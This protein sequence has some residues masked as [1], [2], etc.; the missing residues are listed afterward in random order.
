[1]FASKYLRGLLL[2]ALLFG[3]WWWG[4][5]QEWWNSFI[6]P[7]PSR[8]GNVAVDLFRRGVLVVHVKTSLLRILSGC[9]VAFGTAFPLGVLCGRSPLLRSLM[10]PSLEAL[11]HIP[12]LA[13][14]PLLILWFGIGETSK[15]MVI[16]MASFFPIF[17]NTLSGIAQ[18][19]PQ[20]L[21]V[22]TSLE[23]SPWKTFRHI[24]LPGALPSV[25]VGLRLG[26]GYS[27][28]ALIGAELIAAASGI[29]Y[30]IHDAEQLSRTDVVIVG[31][32]LMGVLGSLMD[33]IFFTLTRGLLPWKGAEHDSLA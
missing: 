3:V 15:L 6:L 8:V 29:G 2:P 28:R 20:L 11:R 16:I 26:L 9:G 12:P 25:L 27:W 23:L 31:V 32:L 17:L 13:V 14:L 1:M 7:S 10:L 33:G 19:N 30:M 4:S 5:S 22:G 24:L 21:E 18:V